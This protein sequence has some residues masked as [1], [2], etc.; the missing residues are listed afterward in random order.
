MTENLLVGFAL[1]CGT[2]CGLLSVLFLSHGIVR[3]M[4][5]AAEFWRGFRTGGR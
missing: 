1:G 3:S 5:A 2:G 4:E